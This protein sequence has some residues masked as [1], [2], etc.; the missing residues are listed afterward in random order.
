M[1]EFKKEPKKNR[2]LSK[3]MIVH[4]TMQLNK[5]FLVQKN[6]LPF[7]WSFCFHQKIVHFTFAGSF[8]L[9]KK[10]SNYFTIDRSSPTISLDI[11]FNT[12]HIAKIKKKM[13]KRIIL[14]CVLIK[15]K[16]V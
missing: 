11:I 14:P 4:Q 12:L 10:N 1:I 3:C 15:K 16:S 2:T 5:E 9:L 8:S 13:R 6:F 7:F